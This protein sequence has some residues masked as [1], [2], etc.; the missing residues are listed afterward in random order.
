MEF[1]A[2][3][4]DDN[5]SRIVVQFV[6]HK[7]VGKTGTEEILLDVWHSDDNANISLDN[8]YRDKVQNLEGKLLTMSVTNYKPYVI[9]REGQEREGLD[10]RI[11]AEFIK[12][13]N[14]TMELMDYSKFIVGT[15]YENGSGF[16]ML[17]RV[18]DERADIGFAGIYGSWPF[19]LNWTSYSTSYT[20]GCITGLMPIPKLLPRWHTVFIS[21]SKQIWL[22]T[23][24]T[25][26]ISSVATYI[27]AKL[28]AKFIESGRTAG[29]YTSLIQCAFQIFGMLVLQVY[30]GVD[31]EQRYLV[32]RTLTTLLDV[33][34]HTLSSTYTG[35]LASVLT[36]PRYG[37]PID[38][39]ME[40]A[41]SKVLWAAQDIAFVF[42]IMN[43]GDPVLERVVSKFRILDDDELKKQALRGEMGFVM[44]T[45]SGQ[46]CCPSPHL[47]PEAMTRLRRMK[48]P[49]YFGHI[50][51]IL[52]KSS[53][54]L[55]HLNR[56]FFNLRETGIIQYW[57]IDV[58]RK[59]TYGCGHGP[60]Y[61][62]GPTPLL[63]DHVQSAF[64]LL[65][66]GLVVSSLVFFWE[67]IRG[68]VACCSK[69]TDLSVH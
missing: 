18:A 61:N 11:M 36:I 26:F 63:L 21:F 52:R 69:S 27:I 7:F 38:T 60:Q 23:I 33:M 49:M 10:M 13:I 5:C 14:F 6:T 2:N 41:K 15:I 12:K 56:L 1:D 8:L 20:R 44:E 19:V 34:I 68:K 62:T 9:L 39:I 40:L 43:S 50:V 3:F 57:E 25:F 37:R 32:L 53:P 30:E 31:E 55:K 66:I 35:A 47:T 54:Y 4:T 58:T 45:M 48:E 46:T 65:A 67:I 29:P 28:S 16:G 17:G 59:F 51:M 42:S 22:A 24:C 64:M